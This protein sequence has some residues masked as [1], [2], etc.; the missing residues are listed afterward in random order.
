ML[1]QQWP[2][3][4]SVMLCQQWPFC[5]SAMLCQQW[6]FCFSAMLC[7]QWP[8]CFSA[9]LCQQWPFC[10]SVMLCQ[11]WP[12][13]SLPPGW[14]TGKNISLQAGRGIFLSFF[15]LINLGW[16][17]YYYQTVIVHLT[18]IVNQWPQYIHDPGMFGQIHLLN[19][20]SAWRLS[21]QKLHCLREN[22]LE[23]LGLLHDNNWSLWWHRLQ[24]RFLLD[25]QYQFYHWVK[26]CV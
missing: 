15:E 26:F 22:I 16:A 1:C 24:K 17:T 23:E 8:F 7:Q 2:F 9:M 21:L 6:P 11:Q 20:L 19:L 18:L 13:F 4:F 14:G 5:L 12:H 10:F 25:C 3:C